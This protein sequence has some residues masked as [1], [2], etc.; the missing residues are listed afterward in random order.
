MHEI[1]SGGAVRTTG[2]IPFL[3]R[4]RIIAAG[5]PVSPG[6]SC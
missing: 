4:S 6:I 3:D 5:C 1:F 2:F